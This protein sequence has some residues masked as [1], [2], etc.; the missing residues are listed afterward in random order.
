MVDAKEA[1]QWLT[2]ELMLGTS[3]IVSHW[4]WPLAAAVSPKLVLTEYPHLLHALN[5]GASK[6]FAQ[7]DPERWQDPKYVHLPTLPPQTT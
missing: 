3:L 1:L 7:I 4:V 2:Q 5:E 6:P